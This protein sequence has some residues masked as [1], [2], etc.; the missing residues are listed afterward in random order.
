MGKRSRVKGYEYEREV[1]NWHRDMGL[2][3]ER[4]PLSGGA[5]YQNNGHDVDVYLPAEPNIHG[6]PHEPTPLCCEAKRRGEI[7][8]W[9]KTWL[10]ENDALFMRDDHGETLVVLPARTWVRMVK[11]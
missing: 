3:A 1:V 6:V 7:P 11:R 8:K 2:R 4:V 10:G 5:R 9:I